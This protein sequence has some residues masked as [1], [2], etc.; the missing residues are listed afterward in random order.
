MARNQAGGGILDQAKAAAGAK[1]AV[2]LVCEHPL[3]ATEL[4]VAGAARGVRVGIEETGRR[5]TGDKEKT[6]DLPDR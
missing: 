4:A 6:E 2:K 5:L 3:I 1:V